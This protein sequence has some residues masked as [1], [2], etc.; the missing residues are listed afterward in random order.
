MKYAGLGLLIQLSLT[1]VRPEKNSELTKFVPLDVSIGDGAQAS[2]L[3]V[4]IPSRGELSISSPEELHQHVISSWAEV[5]EPHSA[6]LTDPQQAGALP[7]GLSTGEA[8]HHFTAG[9]DGVVDSAR[10]LITFSLVPSVQTGGSPLHIAAS[11]GQLETVRRLL[12][13]GVRVDEV[14]EDGNTALHCAAIMG[15]LAVVEL[16]LEEE[17][18]TEATGEWGRE[19]ESEFT[20][21][22]Y[23]GKSGATPLMMAAAM[24]HVEVRR[25]EY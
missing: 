19:E 5:V 11:L 9:Q 8:W 6:G 13:S 21:C 10:F 2:S 24:G 16:L 15:H 20:V 7:T 23:S 22:Y 14:K 18:D 25:A 4:L 17:A 3:Q 12:D 1:S